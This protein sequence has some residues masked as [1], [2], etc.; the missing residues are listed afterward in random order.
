ML[1][2]SITRAQKNSKTKCALT[3]L[4]YLTAG[5][6]FERFSLFIRRPHSY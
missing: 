5:I 1:K 3:F 6:E 2:S 4:V